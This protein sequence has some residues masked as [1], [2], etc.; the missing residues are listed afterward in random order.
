MTPATETPTKEPDGERTITITP[1]AKNN[2]TGTTEIGSYE[3]P[4]GMVVDLGGM[5]GSRVLAEFKD[6]DGED[7]YGEFAVHLTSATGGKSIRCFEIGPYRFEEVRKAIGTAPTFWITDHALVGLGGDRIAISLFA[8]KEIDPTKSRIEFTAHHGAVPVTWGGSL[9]PF[10]ITPGGPGTTSS[11]PTPNEP[12]KKSVIFEFKVPKA[13]WL[14]FDPRDRF[15]ELL[16]L[17]VVEIKECPTCHNRSERALEGL[18]KVSVIR[19]AGGENLLWEGTLGSV[20]RMSGRPGRWMR[21]VIAVPDD[22]IRV[23]VTS[24]GNERLDPAITVVCL[25]AATS[26]TEIPPNARIN[27]F[28]RGVGMTPIADLEPGSGETIL[29]APQPPDLPLPPDEPSGDPKP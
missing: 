26:R 24:A 29:I 22:L 21:K 17:P 27:P 28:A 14:L 20:S 6:A 11:T 2:P 7:V 15:Q 3:I 19:A 8:K 23:E 5:S 4:R 9:Y 12:G 1:I 13:T 25:T 18:G 16:L 10:I